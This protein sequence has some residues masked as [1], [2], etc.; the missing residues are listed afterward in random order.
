MKKTIVHHKIFFAVIALVFII[1]FSLIPGSTAFCNTASKD[2]ANKAAQAQEIKVEV[3]VENVNL[4][5][6]PDINSQAIARLKIGESIFVVKKA[7]NETRVNGF[8]GRWVF[9]SK[10]LYEKSGPLSL[11][12]W[13][14]DYYLAYPHSFKR[15]TSWQYKKI[16]IDVGDYHAEYSFRKD[17]SF[18]RKAEDLDIG[19][20]EET[21]SG[22]YNVTQTG[23]DDIGKGYVLRYLN[24]IKVSDDYLYINENNKLCTL[25]YQE[26]VEERDCVSPILNRAKK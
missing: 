18:I 25:S 11:Q 4:R 9:I 15:V 22:N 12:G 1:N 16:V 21:S 26:C 17:G 8:K 7:K 3:A 2:K 5:E 14:F 24:L 13:V 6:A 20:H 23:K 10:P 19:I